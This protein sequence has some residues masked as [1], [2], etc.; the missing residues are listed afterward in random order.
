MLSSIP[1]SA[2]PSLSRSFQDW[3]QYHFAF[4]P[5]LFSGRGLFQYTF[6]IVP[7]RRPI[8]VVVGKPVELERVEEPSDQ[9]IEETHKR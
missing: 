5:A 4:A 6:G 1:S 2:S 3:F 8:H 7:Q 9:L